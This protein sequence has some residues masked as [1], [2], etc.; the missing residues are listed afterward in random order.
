MT[1]LGSR[2]V[3]LLGPLR[4][5]KPSTLIELV[6]VQNHLASYRL[7]IGLNELRK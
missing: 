2:I 5:K 4:R 7:L 1:L 3:Q 6:W